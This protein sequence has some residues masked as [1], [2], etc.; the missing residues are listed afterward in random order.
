MVSEQSPLKLHYIT[1]P[2]FS[3]NLRYFSAGFRRSQSWNRFHLH[4]AR[5]RFPQISTWL[6]FYSASFPRR[7]FL[8]PSLGACNYP[9]IPVTAFLQNDLF[10]VWIYLEFTEIPTGTSITICNHKHGLMLAIWCRLVHVR[11]HCFILTEAS[12]CTLELAYFAKKMSNTGQVC[13]N[14]LALAFMRVA[15]S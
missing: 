8:G 11:Q 13:K 2:Q 6:W 7:V 14:A 9:M 12:S 15:C 10:L 5:W 3:P 4:G 1:V